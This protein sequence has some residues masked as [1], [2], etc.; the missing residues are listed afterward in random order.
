MFLLPVHTGESSVINPG[1]GRRRIVQEHQMM[2]LLSIYIIRI[3][4]IKITHPCSFPSLG[5]N[6]SGQAVKCLWVAGGHCA[7]AG[8]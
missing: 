6:A 2:D 7:A 1:R 3:K 8:R 4:D 5:T